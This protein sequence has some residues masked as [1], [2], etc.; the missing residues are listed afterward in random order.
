MSYMYGFPLARERRNGHRP[1]P[2][3]S[4]PP[5]P[6]CLCVGAGLKPA[7]TPNIGH[8]GRCRPPRV[9]PGRFGFCQRAR[10]LEAYERALGEDPAYAPAM[11]GMAQLKLKNLDHASALEWFAKAAAADP[12]GAAARLHWG[13]ALWESG[14]RESALREMRRALELRPQWIVALYT[15]AYYEHLAGNADRA[16]ILLEQALA[17]RPG[18]EDAGLLL[19]E[20]RK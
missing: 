20:I 18:F 16:V 13:M 11:L 3:S 10:A 1:L 8:R 2:R 6:S 15:L 14:D 7:R 19:Q 4:P 17:L 9:C 12:K 5:G